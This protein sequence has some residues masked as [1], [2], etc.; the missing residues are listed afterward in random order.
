MFLFVARCSH[1]LLYGQVSC[2]LCLVYG[3]LPFD[4]AYDCYCVL[5]V[6]HM[7][8]CMVG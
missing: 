6:A 5:F 8:Y 2:R 1:A 3:G 7:C 4:V